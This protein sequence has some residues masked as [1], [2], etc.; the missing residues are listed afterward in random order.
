[1]IPAE[2]VPGDAMANATVRLFAGPLDGMVLPNQSIGPN[3]G[4]YMVVPGQMQKVI[5]DPDP[6]PADQTLW[7][8]RGE[9]D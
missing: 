7:H 1:M 6:P 4:T 5:Y 9:T 3:P 2:H 8:Y